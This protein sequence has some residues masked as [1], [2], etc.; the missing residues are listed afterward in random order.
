MIMP[1]ILGFAFG[2]AF[3]A[4]FVWRFFALRKDGKG[5]VIKRLG[6]KSLMNG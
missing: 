1:F 5:C 4:V 2:V 6:K 3:V